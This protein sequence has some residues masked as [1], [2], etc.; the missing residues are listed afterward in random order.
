MS[1]SGG[2]SQLACPAL[3]LLLL[4]SSAVAGAAPSR[5]VKGGGTR[6]AAAQLV[7]QAAA[8]F[9]RGNELYSQGRYAEAI[10]AF[11]ASHT[12]APHPFALFN[13][14]RCYQ[15]LAQPDTALRYYH[16]SLALTKDPT[17]RAKVQQLIAAL[18]ALPVSV[19]VSS[20]PPGAK[21]FVDA[22]AKA[23]AQRTPLVVKLAPGPHRLLLRH[24]GYRLA[25]RRL[26]VERRKTTTLAVTLQAEPRPAATRPIASCPASRPAD[27]PAQPAPKSL[28]DASRFHARI[29][30]LSVVSLTSDRSLA[31]GPGLQLHFTFRRL[32]VGAHVLLSIEDEREIAGI[33]LNGVNY[34]R[35]AFRRLQFE[36][37][38]GWFFPFRHF[39]VYATGGLGMAVDRAIFGNANDDLV[40]ERFAFAWS[41]GGGIEAPLTPWL[42]FG[43]GLRVGL[44]HGARF[45]PASAENPELDSDASTFPFGQLW[46]SAAFHL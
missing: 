29:A 45:Q 3:T 34:N 10:E 36:L 38:G 12:L 30:L 39:Y 27:R 4:L 15:S 25:T 19:L 43:A 40:K 20:K 26:V 21:V 42:S 22:R 17:Q 13:I 33:T 41:L 16:Q 5:P 7:E 11:R 46:A 6:K 24:P 18:K 28:V 44:A 23:E 2:R 35:A 1:G 37:Q 8:H 14:A 31:A 9:D 32:V